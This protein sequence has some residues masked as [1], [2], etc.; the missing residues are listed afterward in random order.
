MIDCAGGMLSG[1]HLWEYK[2]GR[3]GRREKLTVM[4]LQH[5]QQV[6]QRA[7]KM[8]WPFRDACNRHKRFRLLSPCIGQLLNAGCY[9]GWGIT[10]GK[11]VSLDWGQFP[12]LRHGY[13]HSADN[14][15]ASWKNECLK[16]NLVGQILYLTKE[17]LLWS[18]FNLLGKKIII[19]P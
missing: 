7:Q 1:T 18:T 3:T 9:L 16:R 11:T 2:V 13:E 19:C 6:L 17:K 14:T 8:G 5:P 10:L 15:P 4:K 12:K